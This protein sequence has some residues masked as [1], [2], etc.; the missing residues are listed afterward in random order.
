V[1]YEEES[2]Q[3]TVNQ[4]LGRDW[5]LGAQYRLSHA[6]LNENYP[7]VT[8]TVY[9]N[10]DG[11]IAP[12]QSLDATLNQV[13]LYAIYNL[14]CGFFSEA[15]ARWCGQNNSGYSPAEPGDSLGQFDVFAGYRFWQRAAQV[16]V[17]VLN[18]GNQNYTLNPLNAYGEMARERTLVVRFQFNF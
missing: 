1:S 15:D 11:P 8:D 5:A 18:I 12:H 17:G 9:I 13:N 14:P 6:K 7:E 2:L 4:L 3:F 10:P 16:T